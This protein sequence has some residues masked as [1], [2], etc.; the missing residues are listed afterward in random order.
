M[1]KGTKT[2]LAVFGFGLFVLISV[3]SI[4]LAVVNKYVKKD[5]DISKNETTFVLNKDNLLVLLK[6][7]GIKYPEIVL[8]QSLLETGHF[9]SPVCLDKCNLFGFRDGK[10]L[11]FESYEKCVEYYK[12]W[13][14]RK[15]KGGDYYNFLKKLPY[16]E[17]SLYICKLKR[18]K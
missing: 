1:D 4:E 18:M 13:Q 8:N 10:Y 17:D 14:D 16:A 5:L 3:V 11:E 15:Y 2:H 6:D 12:R 7:K 9:T